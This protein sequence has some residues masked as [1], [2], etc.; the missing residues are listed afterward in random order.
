MSELIWQHNDPHDDASHQSL[1]N[2]ALPLAGDL[3]SESDIANAV[4]G[5]IHAYPEFISAK[6]LVAYIKD[7]R[8]TVPSYYA[9]RLVCTK[10][11]FDALQRMSAIIDTSTEEASPEVVQ[12][13]TEGS[14]SALVYYRQELTSIL[15]E[16]P[17]LLAKH[18]EFEHAYSEA[19]VQRGPHRLEARAHQCFDFLA[20]AAVF[21]HQL[22]QT[23]YNE[24]INI[25]GAKGFNNDEVQ[26][27]LRNIPKLMQVVDSERF[28]AVEKKMQQLNMLDARLSGLLGHA[29]RVKGIDCASLHAQ[30]GLKTIVQAYE[31]LDQDT[32]DNLR[33]RIELLETRKKIV[34]AEI[35]HV[36]LVQDKRQ[37]RATSSHE[38]MSTDDARENFASLLGGIALRLA[39]RS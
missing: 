12:I 7:L 36:Q 32:P 35:R 29:K 21:T 23:T 14:H 25:L 2:N 30:D 31:Y 27:L 18:A 34:E 24:I 28:A 3:S 26:N 22:R 1:A 38:E 19:R 5:A 37:Q 10:P 9:S 11:V 4:L 13:I 8:N 6:E 39:T 33:R 20:S 16:E 15:K 17:A